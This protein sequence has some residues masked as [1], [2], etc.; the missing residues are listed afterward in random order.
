M[1][2]RSPPF[3]DASSDL[4]RHL[5]TDGGAG[6]RRARRLARGAGRR[7]PGAGRRE[8]LRQERHQ[9]RH[10]APDAGT[11]ARPHHRPGHAA[12]ADGTVRDLLALPEPQMRALRG[13][14]ISMIFQEPMTSLNPVHQ[15]GEQI[16]EA[17]A[18]SPR[19]RPPCRPAPGDRAAR[20]RRHPGAAPSA[21]RPIPHHLS[22][23]MRQR[24]MIAMALACDPQLLIADEP[25]TA[26]DVTVQAQI[27]DLLQE[28]QAAHRHGDRLHHP[29][30][31]RGGRDRRP[32]HGHVCRPHRRGGRCRARAE[33]AADALHKAACCARCR[34]WTG[35]SKAVA[36][37]STPS[38]A[39]C[40]IPRACR[41]AAPSSRAATMPTR[42]VAAT[43]RARAR[44]G[45]RRASRALPSLARH[46][47]GRKREM[48]DMAISDRSG[49]ASAAILDVQGVSPCSPSAGISSGGA[50]QHGAG[51]RGRCRFSIAE[52]EVL[53]LVGEAARARPRS[54]RRCCDCSTPTAGRISLRRPGHHAA[55]AR[56]R[57]GRC[58]R[59]MQLVFQD[60]FASLEPAQTVRADP[61]P[62]PSCT[63]RKACRG[64]AARARRSRSWTRSGSPSAM[65]SAS[66]T[67]SRAA[68][69]SASASRAR[70]WSSPSSWSPTSRSRPSTSRSRPRS[71]I[72][73]S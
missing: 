27:L 49:S 37:S 62:L 39:A 55:V 52:G 53:G 64:A 2:A 17:L 40:P 23:G 59:R 14:A 26:L 29:Q 58:G 31:G 25:T 72:C 50:A 33:A 45:G 15:V 70:S 11:A 56:R 66:R 61:S 46:C 1:G 43:P 10:H 16:A 71:S 21:C 22:G 32:R 5:P 4:G 73:S 47:R 6:A 7:D 19:S 51:G 69:A 67:S 44:G 34:A 48:S 3:A 54:A 36:R 13:D 38:R 65:P 9:P 35:A 12:R 30:S 42:S 63:S 8:R 60:P 24:V 57:C 20:A 18:L 41:R 28:L 68:S